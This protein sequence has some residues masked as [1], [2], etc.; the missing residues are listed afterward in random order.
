MKFACHKSLLW[1]LVIWFALLQTISPFVHAHY[2]SSSAHGGQ[3]MHMHDP[4]I[5]HPDI[6]YHTSTLN[7]ATYH[8]YVVGLGEAIAQD[9]G[10]KLLIALMLVVLWMPLMVKQGHPL[11]YSRLFKL[12]PRLE[13][14]RLN[15]RAPPRY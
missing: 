11:H 13:R 12:P 6:Y 7:D 10:F 4:G 3:T 14:T 2:G 15:P 8:G 1:V 5:S 9:S